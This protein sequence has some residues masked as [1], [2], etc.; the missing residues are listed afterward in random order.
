MEDLFGDFASTVVVVALMVMDNG[1]IGASIGYGDMIV[2]SVIDRVFTPSLASF[3]HEASGVG[4]E[5]QLV[6]GYSPFA[7]GFLLAFV[8]L[9][10]RSVAF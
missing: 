5:I 6:F 10:E 7:F 2:K 4:H 9:G 1:W 3:F 8:F